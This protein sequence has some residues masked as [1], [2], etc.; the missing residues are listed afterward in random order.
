MSANYTISGV[1]FNGSGRGSEHISHVLLHETNGTTIYQG[2]KTDKN[3]VVALL[4]T[5]TIRTMKWN[6]RT[7]GWD[8]G[9]FVETEFRNGMYF[10]R[11]RADGD[12]TNNLHH[13]I[14]MLAFPI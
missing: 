3:T 4:R 10:L 12:V 6:Y 14:H 7:T 11:T 2:T 9:A 8:L 1:W 5:K 13:L